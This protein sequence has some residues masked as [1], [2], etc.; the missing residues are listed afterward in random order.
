MK[1]VIHGYIVGNETPEEQAAIVKRLCE[2]YIENH[3]ELD[4][5]EH[6]DFDVR[7]QKEVNL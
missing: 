7:L 3:P 6:L 4:P 5:S 2:E 1:I